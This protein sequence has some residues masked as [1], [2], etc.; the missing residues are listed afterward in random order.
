MNWHLARRLER[1]G[2]F[3]E[4]TLFSDLGELTP[5]AWAAFA[6]AAVLIAT[7][8]VL[9]T[10]AHRQQEDVEAK[11]DTT[12]VLVYGALCVAL[13][14]LLSY[15]KLFRMPQG[16]SLTVCSLLPVAFYANRF[17]TRR[18]LIA[19]L[20]LGFLQL[21]QD[22]YVI[23]WAQLFLDYPIAFACIGLA[24]LFPKNLPV[25]ILVG[26]IGR[27]LCST[28]SG[29]IFF[30]EYAWEGWNPWAYSL[31]YNTIALGPDA[32]IC[33][34]VALLPPVKRAFERIVPRT[35]A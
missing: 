9:L 10:R 19:G 29:A 18:G 6:V 33:M 21:L 25:G 34:V 28:L 30:A 13:S 8:I 2:Q 27:I 12:R 35:A 4:F 16:G 31:A 24:G 23:H 1:K 15:L 14:F 32:I 20:A 5:L 26:G 7:F 22:A 17:G 11:P 3:M